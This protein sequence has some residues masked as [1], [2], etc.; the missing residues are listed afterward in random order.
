MASTFAE[1]KSLSGQLEKSAASGFGD[2]T[3]NWYL[4]SLAFGRGKRRMNS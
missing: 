1:Q 2:W 3:Y 4:G